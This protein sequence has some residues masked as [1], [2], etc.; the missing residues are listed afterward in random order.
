[1][2]G[3]ACGASLAD[4]LFAIAANARLFLWPFRAS[5]NQNIFHESGAKQVKTRAARAERRVPIIL[6]GRGFKELTD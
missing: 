4:G 5:K 3:P 6:S 1:M 2:V